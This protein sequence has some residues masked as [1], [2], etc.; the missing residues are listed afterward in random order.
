MLCTTF[1]YC[2]LDQSKVSFFFPLE[3]MLLGV[4]DNLDSVKFSPRDHRA[5]D[6]SAVGF[7]E[8]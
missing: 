8:V 5:Q 7:F 1:C 3:D 4:P 6:W 2:Q